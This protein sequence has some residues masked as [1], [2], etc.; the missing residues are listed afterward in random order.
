MQ[1]ISFKRVLEKANA[2]YALAKFRKAGLNKD[3]VA[4]MAP[5]QMPQI[6]SDQVKAMSKAIID[7]VNRHLGSARFVITHARDI[8]ENW[9]RRIVKKNSPVTYRE[10]LSD[11]QAF[12]V[13]GGDQ[14]IHGY[15]YKDVILKGEDGVEYPC[16]RDIFLRTYEQVDDTEFYVK[17]GEF[18]IVEIPRNVRVDIKTLEGDEKDIVFPNYLAIGPKSEVYPLTTDFVFN[19]LKVIS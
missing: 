1:K 5:E 14:V 2:I 3:D 7:E 10:L 4:Y 13:H 15:R 16:K 11:T 8:P 6:V 9:T 17:K 12:I 19:K 18:V